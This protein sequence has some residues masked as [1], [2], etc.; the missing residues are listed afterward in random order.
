MTTRQQQRE[1]ADFS[2]ELL[3][4]IGPVI[5]KPMFGGFGLFLEGLMFALI[6]DHTLY[7]KVDETSKTHFTDLGLEPFSYFKKD[8]QFSL[9]YFQAPEQVFDDIDAMRH[10]GNIAYEAAL[11]AALSKKNKTKAKK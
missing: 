3:Q 11:R 8:K 6:A 9:N 2:C 5:S 1:F 7:L 10:W 4:G